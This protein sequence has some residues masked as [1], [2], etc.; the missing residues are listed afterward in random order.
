MGRRSLIGGVVLAATLALAGCGDSGSSG[1]A[2]PAGSSS[3][4]GS[5]QT[6]EP[7]NGP[8][9]TVLEDDKKLQTVDNIIPAVNAKKSSDALITAVN[10][11]AQ[12]LGYK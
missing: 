7:V 8:Q 2:A 9:L 4:G 10:K 6:C 11:E 5:K 3:G 1:T 12:A